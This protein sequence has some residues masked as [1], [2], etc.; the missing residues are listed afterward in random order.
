MYGNAEMCICV[1]IDVVYV[2]VNRNSYAVVVVQRKSR[3][4]GLQ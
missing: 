3:H 1:F 4:I 2:E